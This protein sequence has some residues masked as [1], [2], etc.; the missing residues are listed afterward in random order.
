MHIITSAVNGWK[1]LLMVNAGDHWDRRMSR[2]M[3]PLLLMFGWYM[4]VENATCSH[5]SQNR[6]VSYGG[7]TQSRNYMVAKT[8]TME[9]QDV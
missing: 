4:R 6:L 1:P 5:T 2:Q 8:F 7:D 3:L 9:A